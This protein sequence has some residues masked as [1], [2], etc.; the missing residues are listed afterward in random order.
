MQ[1][2]DLCPLLTYTYSVIATSQ[3]QSA[4]EFDSRQLFI[5]GSITE[6]LK[7][8]LDVDTK[9]TFWIEVRST[10]PLIAEAE[11]TLSPQ[12][13]FSKCHFF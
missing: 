5:D 11:I 8:G 2:S 7:M 1:V 3:N 12:N 4:I 13:T 6:E 10:H 9:Y